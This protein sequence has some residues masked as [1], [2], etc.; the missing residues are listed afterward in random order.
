[1]TTTTQKTALAL[2]VLLAIASA[3]A[4][5]D[6]SHEA[7]M[8]QAESGN[9]AAQVSLA[10]SYLGEDPDYEKIRYWGGLA[11]EQGD[12]EGM[13]ILSTLYRFGYGV[14][15]DMKEAASWALQAAQLNHAPSQQAVAWHLYN[16]EGME[17]NVPQ[18]M[19]WLQL[20]AQ[21][22]LPEAYT[23]LG[24][25]LAEGEGLTNNPAMG[26]AYMHRGAQLGDLNAA[27]EIAQVEATVSASIVEAGRAAA[28]AWQE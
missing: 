10:L 27:S 22:N 11:A 2:A 21:Q 26:L 12:P 1:M 18:S 23:M 17:L 24:R 20:S 13:E 15:K 9:S 16:G 5:A 25:M 7:L 19:A 8:A 4:L 28:D 14:D 6:D 3:P